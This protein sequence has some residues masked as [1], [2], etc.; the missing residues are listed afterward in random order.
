MRAMP[1]RRLDT[2]RIASGL[3]CL[4]LAGC[5]TQPKAPQRN[6][7]AVRAEIV[8]KLPAT[9]PD[10]QG[11]ADDVY[12]ALT[13]QGIDPSPEH[14]CAVLAVTEQESTYQAD[15]PVP[16]LPAIARGEIDRRAAALH[17]PGLLVDAALRITSPDGRSYAQRLAAV[18][19]E[20]QLS[21]LYEDFV[22]MVPLG[23]KLF[24][25][26]NP[27]RTG[28]P[29]QV[30]IAFAQTRTRGYPYPLQ[31]G[32]RHEV[33][34]RRGGLYFG[35]AHLL[36]YAAHYDALLYRFADFNAGWYASRNAAFQAAVSRAS[37]IK[38]ALDGDL[39]RPGAGMD[40]PGATERA[41]RA[42]GARLDMDE[43][44]IRRALQQGDTLAFEDSALYARV[45]ALGDAAAGRPL[46]RAVL[47]GIRLESPKITRQLTT[48]WF[49]DR[50]N[51]RWQ[52]CM[53]R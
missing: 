30:S 18:R 11:W 10:A 8:R 34:T 40:D 32:V 51:A 12:V 49:A 45:F 25:G 9:L 41:V 52:R 37:G 20:R 19:T 24:G 28:G 23:G 17:V 6:P 48:A 50:V 46:P 7:D 53:R 4:L 44:Q 26:L 13:A 31:A 21:E 47:P 38:L 35:T 15:P 22:G 27:V 42:L 36:G 29:M 43:G 14:V 16:G 5:A 1:P 2:I 33:F 3:L 39:L